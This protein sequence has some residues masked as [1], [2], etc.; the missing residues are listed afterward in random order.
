MVDPVSIPGV[1]RMAMEPFVP[2]ASQWS[3]NAK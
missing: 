2:V 1:L 3:P